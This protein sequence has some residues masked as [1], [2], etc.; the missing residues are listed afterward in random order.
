VCEDEKGEA[1]KESNKTM[2]ATIASPLLAC[3]LLLAF[4]VCSPPALASDN[5]NWGSGVQ[6]LLPANAASNPRV[7]LRSVSCASPGN[8]TAVGEYT[9]SS[10][11]RAG[12]IWTETSGTWDTGVASTVSG[13]VSCPSVGNCTV[14]GGGQVLSETGGTWGSA[15]EVVPPANAKGG[16]SILSQLSCPSAGNCTAAGGYTDSS[17]HHEGLLVTETKGTWGTGIETSLPANAEP[18]TDAYIESLSCA[19]PGNCTAVGEYHDGAVGKPEGFLVTETEGTWASAV[20][21]KPPANAEPDST[22]MVRGVSCGSVGNCAVVGEYFDASGDLQ[23]YMLNETEGTW[24]PGVEARVP[25]NGSSRSGGVLFKE[26]QCASAGNCTA[27]GSGGLFFTETSG[28][29]GTGVEAPMPVGALLGPS[30]VAGSLSCP[31]AGDCSYVDGY[32]DSTLHFQGLLL[33]ENQGTWSPALRAALPDNAATEPE[34]FLYS[35]SCASPGH[36]TAV[37]EYTNSE[38]HVQ[39]LLLT[40]APATADL[41]VSGPLGGAFVGSPI[42]A[43]Q[44]SVTL[45]G[46]SAPSGSITFTVFG[47]QAT[48]PSSCTSS[49]TV[50]GTASAYG[51]GTYQPSASFTPPSPGKYWWYAR[52]GGDVGDEPATSVCGG[53]SMTGTTVV[54]KATPTL[55][56]SGPMGGIA[57]SQ[58]SASSISATLAEGFSPTGPIT[59]TVFG[60]QSSPPS[61]CASGGMTV[62]TASVNGNGTYQPS[63][64]F[65]P[66]V[67]GDYWWYA[68]YGGDTGDEPATSACG[69]LMAQTVVAPAPITPSNS[70]NGSSS[71]PGPGF[72]TG[73]G[74]KPSAPALSHVALV[75]KRVAAKKSVALRLTLSQAATIK[76]VIA[77]NVKGHEL[78]GVCKQAAKGRR[79]TTTAKRRTL[80]FSGSTGS[81]TFKLRLAGLGTGRYTTTIT[82]E[83][84]SGKSSLVRLAFTITRR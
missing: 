37:G 43:S 23:G 25:A 64:G 39:G 12:A 84:A 55:S 81:N 56:A 31:L 46:G 53:L 61:P 40:A 28:V 22:M 49:G 33:T 83:N 54:P 18:E 75:S 41:S 34:V 20:Q 78:G 8:C 69:A 15:T 58:I 68:S 62:G 38:G 35:V 45:T 14:I 76:V 82:A 65:T 26:V 63:A 57:G 51:D 19:S 30:L 10:N 6:A 77:Q 73:I 74:A 59:F 70:G 27:V 47:P 3:E 32:E 16:V 21:A 80:T 60:P 48:A 5:D 79:C 2:K 52:Y 36:C 29:W 44:V 17:G 72:G 42:S 71:G 50:V 13:V 9:D 67:P 7:S 66:S 1:N 11:G 4:A 24:G